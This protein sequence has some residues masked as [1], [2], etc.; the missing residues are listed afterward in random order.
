M[1][2]TRNSPRAR[3]ERVAAKRF[4]RLER[5]TAPLLQDAWQ[6]YSVGLRLGSVRCRCKRCC[7]KVPDD[8]LRAWHKSLRQLYRFSELGFITKEGFKAWDAL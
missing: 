3:A 6:G 2:T 7:V 4:L 8:L 5:T 1:K